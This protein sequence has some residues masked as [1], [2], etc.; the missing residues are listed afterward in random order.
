MFSQA[1]N[2]SPCPSDLRAEL[3]SFLG[4]TLMSPSLLNYEFNTRALTQPRPFLNIWSGKQR[5]ML[6]EV[7]TK[8]RGLT[9]PSKPCTKLPSQNN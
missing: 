3:R 7:L 6:A 5:K 4:H 9:T 2:E 8:E 1:P